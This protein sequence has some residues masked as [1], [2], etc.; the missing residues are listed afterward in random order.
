MEQRR[1]RDGDLGPIKNRSGRT[2]GRK[3]TASSQ[4]L[5]GRHSVLDIPTTHAPVESVGSGSSIQH[6]PLLSRTSLL[7]GFPNV[8]YY[9][10]QHVDYYE[11]SGLVPSYT[12]ELREHGGNEGGEETVH[13]GPA[14]GGLQDPESCQH[15]TN[16][17][18]FPFGVE[19]N[20]GQASR[21]DTRDL[22]G[23]YSILEFELLGTTHGSSM[24]DY[25]LRLD[26]IGVAEVRW[27][28]YT[29]Q[30]IEGVRFVIYHGASVFFNT[31]EL[32]MPKRC[33]QHFGRLQGIPTLRIITSREQC[34]SASTKIACDASL[35]YYG[36]L[37]DPDR[38]IPG[39]VYPSHPH[40]PAAVILDD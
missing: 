20:L 2:H 14:P 32:H 25:H 15:T 36:S 21:A 12:L 6:P 18:R 38:L 22:G 34:R 11:S 31:V 29:A 30:E 28:L 37:Y 10:S 35:C 1:R 26:T 7:S 19:K 5:R 8:S 40:I 24:L 13:R 3:V 4:G 39:S 16:M 17:L 27:T 33:I 9:S 23:C